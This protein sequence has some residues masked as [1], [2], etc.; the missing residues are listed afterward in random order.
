[1]SDPPAV[2]LLHGQPGNALHWRPVIDRLPDDMQIVADDRPG[3]G[4]NLEPATGLLGNAAAVLRQ[5]D[6]RGLD[7]AVVAGH[8]WA[9]G[10]ALAL[11]ERHAD[12]VSGLA[13]VSSIGPGAV[14]IVDRAL[15]FP[16]LGP[17]VSWVFFRM[18]GPLMRKRVG[19][20]A[21][22]N[23]G[24]H[25]PDEWRTFLVEQQTMVDELPGLVRALSTISAPTLV[26]AGHD[27][28]IVPTKVAVALADRIPGATLRLLPGEGHTLPLTAPGAVADAIVAV[29]TRP[30]H[31]PAPA[32]APQ[33]P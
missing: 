15:T 20:L 11:A 21:G 28:R 19:R 16:V 23:G 8:S 27:D 24:T 10:I 17:A 14:T 12:R 2:V 13:L 18:A 6:R 26:L 4:V 25:R 5:M 7:R 31:P 1:V 29:A 33:Q 22:E 3:Y 30:V 32:T 9:G